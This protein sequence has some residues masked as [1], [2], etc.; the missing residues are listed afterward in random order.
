MLIVLTNV[1]DDANSPSS[2]LSK[3]ALAGL[4]LGII[5][6]AVALS[7]AVTLLI[8]RMHVRNHHALS[9]RRHCEY[10][11]FMTLG[12]SGRY[13][14]IFYFSCNCFCRTP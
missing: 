3:G 11:I 14:M 9:R 10:L 6:G 1:T 7:A 8:L 13:V 4:V 2:G 5:A 12:V